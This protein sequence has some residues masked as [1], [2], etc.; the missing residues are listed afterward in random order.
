VVT[1]IDDRLG[2]QAAFS[3]RILASASAASVMA[4]RTIS[5][6]LPGVSLVW[7]GQAEHGS[8]FVPSV[9]NRRRHAMNFSLA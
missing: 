4:W 1:G 9:S 6:Q 3:F 5:L 7:Q 8:H 2:V